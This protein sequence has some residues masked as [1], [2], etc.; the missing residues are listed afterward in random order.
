MYRNHS[1]PSID[2]REESTVG[3]R[4]VSAIWDFLA[5]SRGCEQWIRLPMKK[6]TEWREGGRVRMA[7]V[8]NSAKKIK[9]EENN[10]WRADSNLQP[11]LRYAT[12]SLPRANARRFEVALIQDLHS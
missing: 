5:A 3:P 8:S 4:G 12:R 6:M 11:L 2:V 10:G 7:N 1:L 9:Q